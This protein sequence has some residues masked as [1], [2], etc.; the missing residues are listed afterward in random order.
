MTQGYA[1][2]IDGPAAAGK[3]TI[4]PKLA[5]KLNGFYLYTGAMYRCLALL[6][7]RNNLG[8]SDYKSLIPLLS[9]KSIHFEDGQVI[10]NGENVTEELKKEN[11]AMMSSK[12]AEIREVR[13]QMIQLQQRIAQKEIEKGR[14]VIA[15][16]RD[17]G[18]KV[19]PNAKL[20]IFLTATPRIRAE[21]RLKQLQSQKEKSLSFEKVLID[22]EN[23][24][25]RDVN[26]EVDPLVANPQDYGY[27]VLDNS[28]LT[29]EETVKAIVDRLSKND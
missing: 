27:F 28:N 18:T 1:I 19:F 29:E 20:K 13:R 7:I 3:G 26:R 11:V 4:A 21:R 9:D 12:V 24:D 10:L 22:V 2:A 5:E 25:N 8:I 14:I 17:T 6:V 15:E 16:G 23:R